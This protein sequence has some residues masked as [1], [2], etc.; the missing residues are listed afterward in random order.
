MNE[1]ANTRIEEFEQNHMLS[2]N[3]EFLPSPF[4][5]QHGREG[6][7]RGESFSLSFAAAASEAAA[8]STAEENTC[9]R[10]QNRSNLAAV[11]GI[12]VSIS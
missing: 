3:A 4:A 7:L 6:K 11:S 9:H 2:Y 1:Q 8:A 10:T 5:R 12:N